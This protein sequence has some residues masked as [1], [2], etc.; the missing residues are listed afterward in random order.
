MRHGCQYCATEWSYTS[1]KA[2]ANPF[3]ELELDVVFTDG[4][5]LEY[6]VPAFWAG[7]QT[8]R[9]RFSP[10]TQ[11]SYQVRSVCSDASNPDLH[12]RT[13][14]LTV[15]PYEGSN[16]LLRHGPL[17]VCTDRRYLEHVDDTPFFWLA[18]TWWMGLTRRLAWPDEFHLLL[19]DRVAKGFSVVQVVAGLYPDMPWRDRRGANESGFPW[20]EGFER[21]DPAYFDMADL[22]IQALVRA[23]VVPCIVGCWGYFIRWM[24]PERMRRHW[25]YL[26]ARYGAYPV[27]WCLAGEA[28]MP[29]YLSGE[30]ESDAAYQR[31]EWTRLAHFLR[32]LDP[33]HHP[34]TIH[35]T[36]RGREQVEDP[37]VLDLE[38]L[39]TGHVDRDAIPATVATITAAYEA[40]PRMPVLN[41]EVCYEGIFEGSRQE[42]QRFIFWACVLCGAC[43]HTYGA[44]GIWQVNTRE[45]PYGPSP[46]G[47]S[48]GDTPWEEA[49]RLPG[50]AHVS[51]GKRLLERYPWWRF[52]P[53]HEWIEPHWTTRNW[54]GPYAAG[55]PGEIRVVYFPWNTAAAWLREGAFTLKGLEPDVAYRS[56]FFD[57]TSGREHPCD[58]VPDSTGDA[59]VSHP[60]IMQDWVLVLERFGG[61]Q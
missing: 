42:V 23:G 37:T 5:G 54:L 52:E 6:R 18:D 36:V 58:L 12:D 57:P 2:Y 48:W 32:E 61:E 33:Y 17:R 27:V 10:P 49:M 38:M 13:D 28:T 15:A 8:W 20:T 3:D 26:A 43:G 47:F 7:D 21:I 24:G 53:H 11:G 50:S 45:R 39:Q 46:H 9:V 44:N 31:R 14:E 4:A 19:A 25:R 16:L 59:S 60:P 1:G 30:R 35:P 55:I 29:Y 51:L 22:R 41:G 56:F 40:D 34:V